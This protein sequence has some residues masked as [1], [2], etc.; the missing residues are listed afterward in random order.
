MTIDPR[1]IIERATKRLDED[2]RMALKEPPIRY[3]ARQIAKAIGNVTK[4][5]ASGK[6]K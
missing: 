6:V 2:L 1:K 4:F 5:T 3:D